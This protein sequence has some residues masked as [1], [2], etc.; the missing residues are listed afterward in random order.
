M[1]VCDWCNSWYSICHDFRKLLSS[2]CQNVRRGRFG[3]F[4]SYDFLK[5]FVDHVRNISYFKVP[6]SYRSVMCSLVPYTLP[7]TLNLELDLQ[8]NFGL[9]EH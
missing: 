2:Y 3:V 4:E 1:E 5:K 8:E 6:N 7:G 9:H